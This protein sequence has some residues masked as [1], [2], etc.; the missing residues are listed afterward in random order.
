MDPHCIL[1]NEFLERSFGDL[2][3]PGSGSAG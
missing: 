2:L 1:R 3:G